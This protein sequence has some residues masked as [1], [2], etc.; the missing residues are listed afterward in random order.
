M[1]NCELTSP[2][3][4]A[5]VPEMGRPQLMTGALPASPMCSIFAPS[6]SSA[7]NSGF[8]TRR[9]SVW[10]PVRM[11][12]VPRAHA[13]ADNVRKTRPEPFASIIRVSVEKFPPTP[14]TSRKPSCSVICAPSC[15]QAFFIVSVSRQRKSLRILERPLARVAVRMARCVSGFDAG[16]DITGLR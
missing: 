16:T 5:C 7:S 12:G 1:T 13:M 4:W 6:E 14:V 9:R 8:M 10:S 3:N 11:V 2:G 15:R